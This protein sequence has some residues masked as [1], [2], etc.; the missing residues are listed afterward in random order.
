MLNGDLS[1]VVVNVHK[2]TKPLPNRFSFKFKVHTTLNNSVTLV[3]TPEVYINSCLSAYSE[4]CAVHQGC[5]CGPN[6]HSKI[7]ISLEYLIGSTTQPTMNFMPQQ[8]LGPNLLC[9]DQA[10]NQIYTYGNI[11]IWKYIYIYIYLST[12]SYERN[13]SRYEMENG[14]P[15]Y[16]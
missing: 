4:M 11:Y 13:N 15:T 16:W 8:R 14:V 2:Y 10:T 7:F 12:L 6:T 9:V 3:G 1:R 5:T